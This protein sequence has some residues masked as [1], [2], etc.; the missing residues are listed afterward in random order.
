MPGT[1]VN[2]A[3]IIA[4]SLIGMLLRRGLPEKIK[5]VIMQGLGLCIVLIGIRGAVQ[6][7]NEMVVILSIVIGGLIGSV[8]GIEK[9]LDRMGQA[10]QNRL[11]KAFGAS[12]IGKG[13]VTASLIFCVGSMA[14]VGSLNAGLKGDYSML[15][16][17]ALLDGVTSMVLSSTLG[18]GVMLSAL[19][20]L[21]Y[22]GGITL[23]AGLVSPILSD[24][25]VTEMSAVGGLLIIGIGLNMIYDKHLRVGDLLPAVFLP[26]LVLTVFA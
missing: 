4:G 11:S 7:E 24:R 16:A 25:V 23:L 1:L 8:I 10:L 22:Q 12:D 9:G 2:A 13:F 20:I 21:V 6:T 17:K 15:Y 26:C 18:P 19:P 14:I 3:A 5:T